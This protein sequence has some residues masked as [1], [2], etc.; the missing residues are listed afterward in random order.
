MIVIESDKCVFCDIDDTL[1]IW[2]KMHAT[3]RPHKEH[4]A[5][6]RR[7]HKRGQPVIFWSAGGYEWC[8]HVVKEL[9]LE[10]IATVCMAKPAWWVDDLTANEV[11]FESS[12]IYIKPTEETVE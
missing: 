9:G 3:Y 12:R 11:L 10:E 4:I 1:I 8:V 5:L 2:D 7:F 6:L